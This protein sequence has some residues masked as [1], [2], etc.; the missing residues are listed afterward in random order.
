[1]PGAPTGGATVS[2]V[3]LRTAVLTRARIE[4]D[5]VMVDDFLNH[6]VDTVIMRQVGRDLAAA[7][8]PA[9][10]G[11]ILTAEA[12]GIPPALAAATELGV[13]MVYA[14]KY[15]GTGDRYSFY[16]EVASPTKGIEYRVEVARRVLEPGRRIAIV[17]DFLSGGRTAEALGEITLEAGCDVAGFG[18]V[19][20]KAYTEGRP[21]LERHGWD[22]TSLVIVTGI[23]NGTAV[24]A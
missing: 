12:S 10:P 14:K 7:L 15:L 11:T 3:D 13:P 22:V 20:E 9:G 1:M 23:E 4:G 21:R 19:V 18:F 24:L 16:R 17:D 5:L 2:S 6:R 8:D